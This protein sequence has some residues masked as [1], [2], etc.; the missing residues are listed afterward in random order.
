MEEL[1]VRVGEIQ[2]GGELS[3][4]GLLNRMKAE[5]LGTP[6]RAQLD[7]EVTTLGAATV[8]ARAMG[9][10]GSG[11]TYCAVGEAYMPQ[12]SYREAFTRYLEILER[13]IP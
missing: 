5:V 6:V 12:G 2:L 10:L 9:W 4:N 8:A 7:T 3:R 13:V 11:E 1:G